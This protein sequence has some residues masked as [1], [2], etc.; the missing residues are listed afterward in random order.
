MWQHFK[1]VKQEFQETAQ[2][3]N[4]HEEKFAYLIES[5]QLIADICQNGLSCQENGYN[6]LGNSK[7]GVYLCKY[8]DVSLKYTQAKKLPDQLTVKMIIFKV[9]FF[10]FASFFPTL[11]FCLFDWKIIIK[12]AQFFIYNYIDMS[13]QTNT[14]IG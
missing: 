8:P 3:A 11:L 1:E 6:V 7:S 13:R 12:C 14:C 9:L 2:E 4:E 5:N 10:G